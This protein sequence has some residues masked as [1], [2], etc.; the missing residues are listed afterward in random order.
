MKTF[1]ATSP[2][3]G[4]VAMLRAEDGARV[5]KG[6][7]IVEIECMKAFFPVDAPAAGVVRLKVALGQVVD[8]GDVVAVIETDEG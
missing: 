4:S 8:T 1:D 2:L 5:A 3:T 6:D 7:A